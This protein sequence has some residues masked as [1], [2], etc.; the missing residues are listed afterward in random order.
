MTKYERVMQLL[1]SGSAF[2]ARQL[3]KKANTTPATVSARIAEMRSEGYNVLARTIDRQKKE[4]F[5]EGSS[6]S[7]TVAKSYAKHGCTAFL[8]M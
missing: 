3:A 6:R 8:A 7:K 2:T 1:Q 5:L 4:Y